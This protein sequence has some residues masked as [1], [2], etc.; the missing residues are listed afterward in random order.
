MRKK[1]KKEEIELSDLLWR[2]I[3]G[4]GTQIHFAVSVDAGHDK[5][6]TWT[7]GTTF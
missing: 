1:K 2:D 7:T 5:E 6:D 4:N 3:E